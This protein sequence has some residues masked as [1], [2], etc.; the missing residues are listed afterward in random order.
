M[1]NLIN[2]KTNM[3]NINGGGGISSLYS[4]KRRDA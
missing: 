3:N 4:N 2:P 1:A